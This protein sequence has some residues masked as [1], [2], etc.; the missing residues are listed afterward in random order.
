MQVKLGTRTFTRSKFDG[1][2]GNTTVGF[3]SDDG[4]VSSRA[5]KAHVKFKVEVEAEDYQG[6]KDVV[7]TFGE[8]I[9]ATWK[10]HLALKPKLTR[11]LSGH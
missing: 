11:T 3:E 4:R 7:S 9:D 8:L 10:E 2:D 5:T 6:L 1:L